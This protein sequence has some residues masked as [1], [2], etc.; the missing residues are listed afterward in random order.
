MN[1]FL[2]CC[3]PVLCAGLM[4]ILSAPAQTAPAAATPPAGAPAPQAP[5]VP[6]NL[7]VLPA[8]TDLRKVMREYAGALGVECSF[9]H[10]PADPVTH[11]ADRASD[12]N[13][14]KDTARYMIQ[15]TDDLNNKYLAEMPNRRY[16]D[17][18]S[19][20]TCHRGEKHPSIFVPPPRPEGNPPPGAQPGGAAPAGT[21]PAA[22]PPAK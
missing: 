17:P 13:P 16:A 14:V 19:C 2:R 4:P 10:A 20:G 9:C 21:P 7:K 11:R 6:K 5:Y 22:P 15:M 1:R 8:N 12:A 3:M 18:I